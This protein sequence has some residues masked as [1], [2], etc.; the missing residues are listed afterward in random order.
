MKIYPSNKNNISYINESRF[1]TDINVPLA[2]V[3]LD[4]NQYT[5]NSKINPDLEHKLM[6]PIIPMQV[7]DDPNKIVFNKFEEQVSMDHLIKK[8]NGKQYFMPEYNFSPFKF[9]YSA[10]I[11]KNMNYSI[12]NTY[13][14]NISCFDGETNLSSRLSK[15]FLNP[16]KLEYI[17]PNVRINGNRES[18]DSLI[19]KNYNDSEFLFVESYDGKYLDKNKTEEINLS[20]FLND[21][22]NVW[23]TCDT[24]YK[25]RHNE[26]Y[27]GFVTF[28]HFGYIRDFELKRALLS[29]NKTIACGNFFNLDHAEYKNSKTEVIHNLFVNSLSPVLIV[30]HIG[31]G[32]EIISHSEIFEDPVKYKDLI[33]EVLMYV[34]LLSYK[35]TGIVNEWI[36]YNVPDYEVINNKVH[37]KTAFKSSL[38]MSE[39]TGISTKDFSIYEVRISDNN[40]D[41][42][43]LDDSLGMPNISVADV[44]NGRL[45]FKM[46]NEKDTSYFEPEKPTGWISIYYNDRIYYIDRM[47]Y[48]IEPDITNSLY[49]TE[50]DDSLIVKL[51][52]FKSSKY[53]INTKTDLTV[54]IK[55][56]KTNANGI[57][58]LMKENYVI[59]YDKESGTLTYSLLE[60]F[61]SENKSLVPITYI[62]TYQKLDNTFITDMRQL[63]GGLVEDTLDDFELLDIGHING[64][65]YRKGNTLIVT[66]PK[67]YEPYKDMILNAINKYK[68]GE[69]YPIVFFEDEE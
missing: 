14:L 56:I 23:I 67:K 38:N 20:S 41:G 47:Y 46:T 60:E 44:V 63:G 69:D 65:P 59:H 34:H 64:R 52:P 12:N 6:I 7:I 42:P 45:I 24:H 21:H 40:T 10:T 3:N 57:I 15:I 22:V 30:E 49:V 5:I 13:D 8:V 25:Y 62:E 27:L 50:Q 1:D 58:K 35:N 43:K 9:S 16:S 11:K 31:K 29:S 51:Y 48:Y 39:L 37:T 66:L 61:D 36:A 55:D 54:I 32:F 4:Y 28:N 33:Y 19:N 68:V 53:N 26:D 17:T 18:I 2:Y